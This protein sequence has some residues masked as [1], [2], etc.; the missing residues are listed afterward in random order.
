MTHVSKRQELQ[1]TVLLWFAPARYEWFKDLDLKWYG[2]P[3]VSNMLM[4]IGGLEF[5][6]CPFSGWYMGTEIGVRDFCDSSRYNILE[7]VLCA[8]NAH[9]AMLRWR[10][11]RHRLTEASC[12]EEHVLCH[13]MAQSERHPSSNWAHWGES[14]VTGLSWSLCAC[15]KLSW[16]KLSSFHFNILQY[17][18]SFIYISIYVFMH[19]HSGM[20]M[21]IW[22][23]SK[24]PNYSWT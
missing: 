12:R 17:V 9:R 2:L 4:E 20:F 1:L 23:G 14:S 10:N 15:Y 22:T 11:Q 24:S 13:Q 7:V 21:R 16:H 6:C 8:K 3:A 18:Y 5:T 19:L